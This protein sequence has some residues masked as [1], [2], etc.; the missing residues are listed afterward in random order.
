MQKQMAFNGL[1]QEMQD[2]I[3]YRYKREQELFECQ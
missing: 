1:S 3:Q 2:E